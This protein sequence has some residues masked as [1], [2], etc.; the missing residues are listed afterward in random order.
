MGVAGAQPG[1]RIQA[2]TP[3]PTQSATPP[4]TAARSHAERRDTASD[5]GA[6][7][8]KQSGSEQLNNEA[9]EADLDASKRQRVHDGVLDLS[10]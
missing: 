8:P 7:T 3:A 4:P 10:V 1:L 2:A 6:K 9:I 5:P